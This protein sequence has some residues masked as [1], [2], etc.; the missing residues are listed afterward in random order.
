VL[1]ARFCVRTGIDLH[2]ANRMPQ[3][4][5]PEAAEAE[6]FQIVHEALTNIERHSG[7]RHSWLSVE[8]T[9]AGLE[10][11]VEDDGVGPAAAGG[12]PGEPAHHGLAI[13]RERA[14]R[15]GADLSVGPRAGGGTVVR[16]VLPLPQGAGAAA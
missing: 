7:A 14:Q 5:L 16:C 12:A 2:V 4:H 15:L 11:R 6:L 9:L 8:P 3:L 10:I 1:T 13:M